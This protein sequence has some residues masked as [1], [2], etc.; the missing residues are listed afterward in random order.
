[1]AAAWSSP[2][3]QF[4][5]AD[6]MFQRLLFI[7]SSSRAVQNQDITLRKL[8]GRKRHT[9]SPLLRM[10]FNQMHDRMETPMHGTAIFPRCSQ[11]STCP[12]R[13]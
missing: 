13:S 5:L 4:H 1:M 8:G 11:K 3:L 10:I 9:E 7:S 12:G 2:A 6:D